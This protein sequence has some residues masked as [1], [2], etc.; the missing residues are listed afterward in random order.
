MDMKEYRL[1][2]GMSVKDVVSC[3]K[4]H[5]P[6]Y[7][8]ITHSMVENP[9]KYGVQLL[10]EA[11]KLLPAAESP[12]KPRTADRHRKKHQFLYR[13]TKSRHEAVKRLLE[14][15][16]DFSTFQSLC[17]HLIS[18]WIRTKENAAPVVTTP[19]TASE[20]NTLHKLYPGEGGLSNVEI[21]T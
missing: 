14:Q 2:T 13:V 15:D 9:D 4:E 17:D 1:N 5:Y 16:K 12:K 19:E 10:P 8:K 20:K 21:C 3:L 18:E 7:S 6:K 11:Q